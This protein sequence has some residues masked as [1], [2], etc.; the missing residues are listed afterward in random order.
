[1]VKESQPKNFREAISVNNNGNIQISGQNYTY[2]PQ[3]SQVVS[4]NFT[5]PTQP[6]QMGLINYHKA[7]Y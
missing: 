3:N 2:T 7:Y 4:N 5:S 1:M 6:Y